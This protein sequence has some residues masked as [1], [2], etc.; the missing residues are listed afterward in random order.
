MTWQVVRSWIAQAD[1]GGPTAG[2]GASYRI[3]PAA[4]SCIA[5]SMCHFLKLAGLPVFQLA[6]SD[7]P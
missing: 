6:G 3:V 2:Q 4:A 1:R 7:L 5:A